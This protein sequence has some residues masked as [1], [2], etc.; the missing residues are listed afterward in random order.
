MKRTILLMISLL[1]ITVMNCSHQ[2]TPQR[3]IMLEVAASMDDI[4]DAPTTRARELYS[5]Y[6]SVCHGQNGKGDGFNAFNLDPKPH[7][8][9]DSSFIARI[10]PDLIQETITKGGAGVGLSSLMPP[11]GRTL[12]KKDIELLAAHVVLLSKQ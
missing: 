10:D 5:R 3:D 6:C 7:S 4:F 2:E 8:F 11:W 9:S 12:T 1:L